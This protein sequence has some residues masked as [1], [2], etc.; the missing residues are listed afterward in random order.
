MN[1][2][3]QSVETASRT[4]ELVQMYPHEIQEH[5][6]AGIFRKFDYTFSNETLKDNYDEAG[7]DKEQGK[8]TR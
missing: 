1:I 8:C 3:A 6:N 5:I 4:T 2:D 7:K